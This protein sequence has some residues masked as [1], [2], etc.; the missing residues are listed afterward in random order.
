LPVHRIGIPFFFLTKISYSFAWLLLDVFEMSET[1]IQANYQ[2][3]HLIKVVRVC[4][5]CHRALNLRLQA[6]KKP[7]YPN[8]VVLSNSK[9]VLVKFS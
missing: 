4:N 3:Y 2:I 6:I 1:V 9:T 5:H 8:P 7:R